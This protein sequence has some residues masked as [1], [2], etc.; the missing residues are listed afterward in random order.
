MSSEIRVE[1]PNQQPIGV[2]EPHSLEIVHHGYFA[3]LFLLAV[4]D[5]GEAAQLI[6]KEWSTVRSSGRKVP[7][8]L[9][10]LLSGRPL[11]AVFDSAH[12]G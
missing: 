1:T 7:R 8:L 10:T 9:S 6:I 12:A 5:S 4:V 3:A 2:A 11:L